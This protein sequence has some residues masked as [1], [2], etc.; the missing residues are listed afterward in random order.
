DADPGRGGHRPVRPDSGYAAGGTGPIT[1]P[2]S[3]AIIITRSF[4]ETVF[5]ADGAMRRRALHQPGAR[6]AADPGHQE[7][8]RAAH[9]LGHDCAVSAKERVSGTASDQYCNGD[10]P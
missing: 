5:R 9:S 6:R 1:E 2:A 3:R 8:Y 7:L 10:F 4:Y